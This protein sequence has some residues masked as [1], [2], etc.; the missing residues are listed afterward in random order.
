MQD[1]IV[2]SAFW[3]MVLVIGSIVSPIVVA[4]INRCMDIHKEKIRLQQRRYD[5][6]IAHERELIE[7]Y[8][9]GLIAVQKSSGNDEDVKLLESLYALI[10]YISSGFYNQLQKYTLHVINGDKVTKED[11]LTFSTIGTI[12]TQALDPQR[13]KWKWS[14][15]R[16]KWTYKA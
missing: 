2:V 4:L 10:P 6:F 7:Q 12:F 8:L 9:R 1:Q 3:A 5:E 15:W 16:K 14:K 11:L 13:R